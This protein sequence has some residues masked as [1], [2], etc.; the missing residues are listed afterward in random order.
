M[1]FRDIAVLCLA[2]PL[3]GCGL[4]EGEGGGSQVDRAILNMNMEEA[5][6]RAD[7]ILADTLGSV[8]PGVE[9]T[10]HVSTDGSC[11]DGEHGATGTGQVTRRVAVMTVISEERRGSFLGVI[12][13]FWKKSGYRVLAVRGDQE[14]PAIFVETPDGFR[15]NLTFGY[16]GQAFFDADTPCVEESPVPPPST[17]PNGPDYSGGKIPTPNRRSD[18]WSASSPVPSGLPAGK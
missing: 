10:H 9:W 12:E 13:R 15:I 11:A 16:K 4:T 8:K 5:A 18:F 7:G 17:E 3:A 2:I 1:K 14:S 6:R